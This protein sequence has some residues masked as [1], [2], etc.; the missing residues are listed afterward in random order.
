MLVCHFSSF[1]SIPFLSETFTA[2]HNLKGLLSTHSPSNPFIVV[3]ATDLSLSVYPHI[4]ARLSGEKETH[5]ERNVKEEEEKVVGGICGIVPTILRTVVVAKTEG[6]IPF[7][8]ERK[9]ISPVLSLLL[10]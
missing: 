2:R 8:V 4:F 10:P 7:L 9:D 3:S 5:F 1:L 6:G